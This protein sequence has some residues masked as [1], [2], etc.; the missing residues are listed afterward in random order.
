MCSVRSLSRCS[1]VVDVAVKE[2]RAEPV[3]VNTLLHIY[4]GIQHCYRGNHKVSGFPSHQE[5]TMKVGGTCVLLR[6]E[7]VR[8]FKFCSMLHLQKKVLAGVKAF[9][10][11]E[12]NRKWKQS[13]VHS[14]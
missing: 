12:R 11:Q 6:K 8:F 5:V 1:N 2:E 9:C 7:R 10:V 13:R 3:V 14:G 4:H